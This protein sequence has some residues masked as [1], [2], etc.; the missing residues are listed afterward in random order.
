MLLSIV[1]HP[2]M[3]L[4]WHKLKVTKFQ[5]IPGKQFFTGKVQASAAVQRCNIS[6]V[7]LEMQLHVVVGS[8]LFLTQ[9]EQDV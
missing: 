3:A 7:V 4:M 5:C 6:L 1:P 2:N 9:L 8:L